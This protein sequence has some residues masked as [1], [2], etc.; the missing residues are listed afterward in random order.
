MTLVLIRNTR[1][2]CKYQGI[3]YG[4]ELRLEN[5]IYRDDLQAG[6]ERLIYREIL[7]TRKEEAVKKRQEHE[8]AYHKFIDQLR[9][10]GI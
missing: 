9:R 10:K 5:D 3:R 7:M 8:E 2:H 6:L 4:V 1:C